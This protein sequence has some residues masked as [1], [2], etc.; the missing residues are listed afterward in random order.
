MVSFTSIAAVLLA[1]TAV[2]A[3]S[4]GASL[5]CDCTTLDGSGNIIPDDAGVRNG[6]SGRGQLVDR[7]GDLK[8]VIVDDRTPNHTRARDF[9]KSCSLHGRCGAVSQ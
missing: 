4:G 8:C 2:A 3:Q 1:A 6:C 5:D 9:L 7:N